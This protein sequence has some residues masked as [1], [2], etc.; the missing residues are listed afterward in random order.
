M[1]TPVFL[2][3]GFLE[4]GK[5]TFIAETMKEPQ[6]AKA[7]NVLIL[8]C[9]EGEEEYDEVS[10]AKQ[11]VSILT[12]EELSQL[13]PE[14]LK[15]LNEFYKPD[16]IMVEYNG[17]WKTEDFF[18]LEF[19]DNWAMA[20]II[21]LVDATTFTTYFNNMRSFFMENVKYSDVVVVNRVDETTDKL[22]IRRAIKPINRQAQ[23]MYETAEG[24][25]DSEIEE[26][27]PFDVDA[28][29]IEIEDDDFGLWYMD[30]MDNPSKYAGKKVKFTG[31][32]FYNDKMPKEIDL[33]VSYWMTATTLFDY[34]VNASMEE[35]FTTNA[36][37]EFPNI[38]GIKFANKDNAVTVNGKT[39][40]KPVYDANGNI[41]TNSYEVLSITINNVDPKAIWNFSFAVAPM[42]YYSDAEHIEKFDFV[43][44]FGVEYGS[45]TFMNEVLKGDYIV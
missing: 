5:T 25:D 16:M 34:L 43:S 4:S 32:V 11:N 2:I 19:P 27:L 29:V 15:Q 3:N 1:E 42:Y 39:Y 40:E 44:N 31:M 33:I 20:Q 45:Q 17:M 7:G 38:S 13:T 12:I 14:F 36:E 41:D 21:T 35:Y 18:E 23:I 10:L 9:E 37:R 6:F 22:A 24:I 30:A 26:V 8:L 28:D